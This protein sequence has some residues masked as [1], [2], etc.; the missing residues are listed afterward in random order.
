MLQS[1]QHSTPVL[2]YASV[3]KVKVNSS[4]VLVPSDGSGPELIPV[5]FKP[6]ARRRLPLRTFRQACGYLPTEERHRP[7]AGAILYCLVTEAHAC[8]GVSSEVDQPRFEPA[9]ST[10]TPHRLRIG[11][12]GYFL[13]QQKKIP[14]I[15][16]ALF[17][18]VYYDVKR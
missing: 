12:G 17:G 4:T 7:S 11:R 2:F 10:V 18:D 14:Q 5:I 9:S 13:P 8:D 6:F 3:K 16:V 1:H 15:W